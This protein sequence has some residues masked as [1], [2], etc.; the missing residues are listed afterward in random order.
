MLPTTRVKKK[1]MA[2]KSRFAVII[3]GEIES[4]CFLVHPKKGRVPS[5]PFGDVTILWKNHL[6]FRKT[7]EISFVMKKVPAPKLAWI[8]PEFANQAAIMM[9][10]TIMRI[11]PK[12]S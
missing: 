4:S 11:S 5:F 3:V 2:K 9:W 6:K 7:V 10:C 12:S 8:R 1:E